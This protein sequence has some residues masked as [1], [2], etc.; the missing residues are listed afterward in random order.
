MIPSA[1]SSPH[2][3][4]GC[5]TM[6]AAS[7][8]CGARCRPEQGICSTR[9]GSATCSCSAWRPMP[10]GLCSAPTRPLA[11]QR[12][13]LLHLQFSPV[14]PRLG[15]VVNWHHR[16]GRCTSRPSPW[17]AGPRTRA[18]AAQCSL[19]TGTAAAGAR[20]AAVRLLRGQLQVQS[21][22]GSMLCGTLWHAG[23]GLQGG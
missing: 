3:P 2:A 18:S 5:C 6:Q 16:S 11:L 21:A 13:V 17:A 8:A 19:Q 22:Q 10:T 7:E 20:S 14:G 9:C 4:A 1:C 15:C 12:C 23:V